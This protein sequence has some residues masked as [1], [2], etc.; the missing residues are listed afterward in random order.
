[1]SMKI[2]YNP[3]LPLNEYIPDGEAHVFGNRVYLYGSHDRAGSDRFCVEDYVVYSVPVDDL[4]SWTRHEVSYR[5]SQ[6]PRGFGRS[7]DELPDYYA[8]DCVR[9]N[10]GRYYLYYVAM[11]PNVHPFGPI[12]VAVSDRPEGPFSYY[13]DVSYEDGSPMLTYLTNDPAVI[14][15]KGRIYLYYGWA[16]GMDMSSKLLAPLYRYVQSKLFGRSRKEI[17]EAKPSIMGCAFLELKDDMVTAKE[18]PHLVLNSLSTA[19]KGT[20]EYEHP[21]YEAASIRK[22]GGEYY[23]VY[24]SG[25]NNELAYAMSKHPDKGFEVKGALISNADLGYKGNKKPKAPAGT[26][27][28]CLEKINGD[29]Y[30]FY[31]RLTNGTD[32]SR[33]AAAEKA[34]MRPDGSFDQVG[35]TSQGLY[36]KPLPGIGKYPAA[37][38]CYL[39]GPRP[40]KI[41]NRHGKE[42][43]RVHEEDGAVF[44]HDVVDKTTIGYRYFAF[45]K[46]SRLSLTYRGNA[47]G[48]V[49]IRQHEDGKAVGRIFVSPSK[50]WKKAEAI[51]S[52]NEQESGLYLTFRGKGKL[53]IREIEFI[54]DKNK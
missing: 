11:G 3:F 33:Q 37:I 8:P 34:K 29:Y 26:I 32:F 18:K 52:L 16:I 6:D 30:V 43:P 28:G 19:K 27:H 15:D 7:D 50:E 31:H 39:Y 13:G 20:L 23:L 40:Y 14:N 24:S 12:A 41:G 25:K 48:V 35:I 36:G 38:A 49:E 5:K 44:I 53:D 2:V 51:R 54:V 45:E 10:D 4:S 46:N 47:E 17:K 1:M 21:F 42:F 9:G 22:F